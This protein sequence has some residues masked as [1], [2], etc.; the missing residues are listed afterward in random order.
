MLDG[1]SALA[2]P[3]P[4]VA[5]WQ[6]QQSKTRKLDLYSHSAWLLNGIFTRCHKPMI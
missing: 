2:V 3:W 5:G 1:L 4:T 6:I